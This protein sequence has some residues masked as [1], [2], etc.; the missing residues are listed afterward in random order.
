MNMKFILYRIL[1][2]LF[3]VIR[4]IYYGFFRHR[5]R[6]TGV[7]A[8]VLF[9]STWWY[10]ITISKDPQTPI[11]M[12]LTPLYCL[13]VY[14]TVCG[15]LASLRSLWIASELPP[16][17]KEAQTLYAVLALLLCVSFGVALF[18][19]I[20]WSINEVISDLK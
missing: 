3:R 9:A 12:I 8:T 4:N 15:T 17:D 1:L 13:I 14:F 6:T 7:L 2:I 5:I 10:F 18:L 19:F 11:G 20:I 16:D